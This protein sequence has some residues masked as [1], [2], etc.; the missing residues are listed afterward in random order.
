MPF[1]SIPFDSLIYV[2]AGFRVSM[3]IKMVSS[4]GVTRVVDL[5]RNQLC[6]YTFL[7]ASIKQ[8]MQTLP[9]SE[10]HTHS[11]NLSVLMNNDKR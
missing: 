2:T 7:I 10:V 1:V 5:E 8:C 3:A 11:F 6:E 9:Q 4:G